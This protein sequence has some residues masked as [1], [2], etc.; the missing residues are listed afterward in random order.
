MLQATV[1]MSAN[2]DLDSSIMLP[3]VRV[4]VYVCE[5]ERMGVLGHVTVKGE[6]GERQSKAQQSY[7]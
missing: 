1:H 5:R 7:E 6:E 2:R 4:C 3:C